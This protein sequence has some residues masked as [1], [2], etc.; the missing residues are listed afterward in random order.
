MKVIIE[1]KLRM[2][3][4]LSADME[5]WAKYKRIL[6]VN[7]QEIRNRLSKGKLLNNTIGTARSKTRN[8]T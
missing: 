5:F 6:A 8:A 3:L 2:K 1:N 7:K 4:L